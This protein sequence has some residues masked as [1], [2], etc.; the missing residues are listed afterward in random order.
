MRL[1]GIQPVVT[2]AI[3]AL[4]ICVANSTAVAQPDSNSDD[5]IKRL[6][7]RSPE[8][9]TNKDGVLTLDEAK[10]FLKA[11]RAKRPDRNRA[12]PKPTHADIKY[13][14]HPRHAID[15]YL[16]ESDE[17]T[18]LLI[19]IHGGG[20]VGGDKRTVSLGLIASMHK[21]GI[22]VAGIHY[23]F[24]REHRFPVPFTDSARAIQFL[25]HNAEKYN[26]DA[27][28]F[29][30]TGGSAGAGIS[31]WLATR[32]DMA[33]CFSCCRTRLTPGIG[34]I[35]RP[36]S[37]PTT[38]CWRQWHQHSSGWSRKPFDAGCCMAT[39]P[40]KTHSR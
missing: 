31:L 39:A 33:G 3:A 17:P 4:V 38:Q 13:G 8:A 35:G 40:R 19:Y 34:T 26:L 32:D 16:V 27:S 29:A 30:A 22:S 14:D 24:I 36:S 28:R 20:F 11:Q 37:T 5:R 2:V 6:L 23:R 7:Q 18:P 12:R 21:E 15:L 1:R 10:A 25:R 9:D